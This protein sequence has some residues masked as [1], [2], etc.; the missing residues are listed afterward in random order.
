MNPYTGVVYNYVPLPG[1]EEKIYNR[2]SDITVSMK[3]LDYLDMPECVMVNH[4]VDMDP[5]E[6]ELYDVMRKVMLVELDGETI[7]A[8]NAACLESAQ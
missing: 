7:D 5:F 6:R 4:Y 3:A 1:A 8:A 2:I